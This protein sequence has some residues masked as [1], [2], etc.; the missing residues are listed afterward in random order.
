MKGKQTKSSHR[1]VKE[2]RTTR[3]L[4]F[5]HMDLMGLMR[6]E[7][8]G[9]KRYALVV[10]DDFSRYSFVS[11][12]REKSE[13][14]EHLKSLFNRIQVEIGRPSVRIRSDRVQTTTL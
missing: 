11:I 5:F 2:I 4:N 12:L 3:P 13:A 6:I 8:I 9:G 14:I 1:K 7:S 10:E